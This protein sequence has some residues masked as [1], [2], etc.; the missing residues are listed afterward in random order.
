MHWTRRSRPLDT[1]VSL[2]APHRQVS[3]QH[4]LQGQLFKEQKL[5]QGC[6]K[7]QKGMCKKFEAA[8]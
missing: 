7:S 5:P 3:T 4:Q 2:G 6:V 8:S 1:P